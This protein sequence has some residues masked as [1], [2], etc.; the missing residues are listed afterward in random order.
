[1]LKNAW[2]GF[3]CAIFAYGQTGSGKSFTMMGEGSGTGAGYIP[4]LCN[5]LFAVLADKQDADA[6]YAAR[7][8]E[9]AC[10]PL[11]RAVACLP[12][13]FCA[14]TRVCVCL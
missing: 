3:N 11:W 8:D 14:F 4:R 2:N 5:S 7:Q 12:I 13:A 1:M 9:G 10:V 6:A